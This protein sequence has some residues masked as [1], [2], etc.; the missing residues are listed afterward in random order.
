M[1]KHVLNE[2]VHYYEDAV[3]NFDDVMKAIQELNDLGPTDTIPL[4]E[5]W[6]ASNDKTFIYGETQSFDLNQIRNMD[7]PYRTKSEFIYLNIMQSLYDVCRDYAKSVGDMDEP[8]L[9]PVFNI[10]KYNTGVGMGAHYDQLDGDKTLRYSLVMYLNDDC[11]G[12]E[13]SFKLSDYEDHNKVIS[14]DL[15]YSVAVN[16]NQIDF[17]VKPKAGSVII[18][19]SSAPYYHIAHRVKSGVKYMVPSHW[20]HNNMDMR[21]GSCG[22]EL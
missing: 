11:E 5:D 8:R 10:K 3:N 20:I 17:G 1:K 13:I 14:P 7:E 15:D 18:F 16:N 21:D 2:M 19:P 12:G 6:T 9:F 4:W 22:S